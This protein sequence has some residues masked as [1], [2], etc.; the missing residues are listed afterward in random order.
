[1]LSYEDSRK[2]YEIHTHMIVVCVYCWQTR[3]ADVGGSEVR[4]KKKKT[5]KYVK[6]DAHKNEYKI[7]LTIYPFP[8]LHRLLAC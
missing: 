1:M 4:R 5:R 7:I 8:E 2:R 6:D 3:K